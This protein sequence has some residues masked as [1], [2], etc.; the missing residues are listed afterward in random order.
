MDHEPDRTVNSRERS[1]DAQEN[2]GLTDNMADHGIMDH[3]SVVD[4]QN[5]VLSNLVRH[6]LVN[7]T[8]LLLNAGRFDYSV[9][10]M[11]RDV[12]Q[13]DS[14]LN[15][16]AVTTDANVAS[17]S[18]TFADDF[19]DFGSRLDILQ[20][21]QQLLAQ[22]RYWDSLGMRISRSSVLSTADEYSYL[23]LRIWPPQ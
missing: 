9:V 11:D 6:N 20:W 18:C 14:F 8:R 22:T 21:A 19:V 23:G 10:V 2:V 12:T 15:M 4:N 3:P 13:V 17:V 16:R 7:S 1:V 5:I